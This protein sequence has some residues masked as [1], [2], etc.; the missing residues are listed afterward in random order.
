MQSKCI[1]ILQEK[2]KNSIEHVFQVQKRREFCFIYNLKWMHFLSWFETI[3][4]VLARDLL[5]LFKNRL[6]HHLL[7]SQLHVLNGKTHCFLHLHLFDEND[8]FISHLNFMCVL[9]IIFLFLHLFL[10]F[11][12]LS[13]RSTKFEFLENDRNI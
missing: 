3:N 12:F 9:W 2:L 1:W 10:L 7:F 6:A 8:L 4:R 5:E 13:W 11:T